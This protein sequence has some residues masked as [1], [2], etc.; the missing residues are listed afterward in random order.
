MFKKIKKNIISENGDTNSVEQIILIGVVVMLV[1]GI[2]S[3][4]SRPVQNKSDHTRNC[5]SSSN[6]VTSGE[7]DPNCK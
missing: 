1:I 5:F 7:I 4:I 3:Y 6:N 2:I